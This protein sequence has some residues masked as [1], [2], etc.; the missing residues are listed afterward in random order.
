M[1]EAVEALL[2][3]ASAECLF[4]GLLSLRERNKMRGWNC[5]VLPSFCAKSPRPEQPRDDHELTAWDRDRNVLRAVY[6]R[7][8]DK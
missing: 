1:S 5:S 6:A 3:P 4:E 8:A 2:S 7:A